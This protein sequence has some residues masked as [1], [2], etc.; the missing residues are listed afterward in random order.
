MLDNATPSKHVIIHGDGQK[1]MS[2]NTEKSFS[3]I[4]GS[5]FWLQ[6]RGTSCQYRFLKDCTSSLIAVM[7]RGQ[8][9]LVSTFD[10]YFK[11]IKQNLCNGGVLVHFAPKLVP[12]VTTDFS[13]FDSA[14]VCCHF[15]NGFGRSIHI[16]Y[17]EVFRSTLV[18]K[19]KVLIFTI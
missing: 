7:Q 18:Q 13:V 11:G 12:V 4:G 9:A 15:I 2:W 3:E 6:S 5:Q 14:V 19:S 17:R 10:V 1:R 8:M 16:G